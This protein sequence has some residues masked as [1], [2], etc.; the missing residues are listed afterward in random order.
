VA[1]LGGIHAEKK[2]TLPYFKTEEGPYKGGFFGGFVSKLVYGEIRKK[3]S[4]VL[5][6]GRLRGKDFGEN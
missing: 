5:L 6:F 1:D 3:K 4:P 2:T